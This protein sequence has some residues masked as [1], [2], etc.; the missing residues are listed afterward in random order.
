[1]TAFYLLLAHLV[2]DFALQSD[3][4]ARNKSNPWPGREPHPNQSW[5]GVPDAYQSPEQVRALAQQKEWW[6]ERDAWRLGHLA[7][8]IHCLVYTAVVLA[9]TW[10][11]MPWWGAAICFASHFVIDRFRL[12]APLM[13]HVLFQGGFAWGKLNPWSI[14]LIDQILHLAT[15]GAI[16]AAAGAN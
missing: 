9:F 4:M 15:L 3:W 1:V 12:A 13:T 8:F 11:W 6:A 5:L 14:I 7:C 10:A 16:A 2:A